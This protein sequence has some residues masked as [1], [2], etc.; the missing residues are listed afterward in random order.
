[1]KNS[2]LKRHQGEV[3]TFHSA[4]PSIGQNGLFVNMPEIIS[5]HSPFHVCLAAKKKEGRRRSIIYF[6]SPQSTKI[7]QCCATTTTQQ[8]TKKKGS[9]DLNRRTHTFVTRDTKV[10]HRHG[11]RVRLKK[12]SRENRGP[13]HRDASR[14]VIRSRSRNE[15]MFPPFSACSSFYRQR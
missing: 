7:T 6:S 8:N 11:G 5:P 10:A 15:E 3:Q 12:F 2:K 13:N 14:C 1:M 4:H 9:S